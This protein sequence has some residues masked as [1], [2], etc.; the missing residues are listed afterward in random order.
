[1][2][3]RQITHAPVALFLGAGASKPFGKMLMGEFVSNVEK[4]PQFAADSLFS[5]IV[6][7]PDGRDLEHLFEELDEWSRKGY[8]QCDDGI[9]LHDRGSLGVTPKPLVQR[10]AERA[11]QMQKDL[12]KEVFNAY[13]DFQPNRK[14]ELV[15]RFSAL[16]ELLFKGLDPGKSPLV[17]FTTNYDPAVEIFCQARSGVYRLCD[18]FVTQ[19]NAGS[20]AWHRESIDQL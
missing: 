10:L 17:I 18:G 14:Q 11:S 2:Y 15:Q 19:W 16:F 12:R 13:R 20:P 9:K 7:T 3:N 8:C 1:M 4:K 6:N 5:E